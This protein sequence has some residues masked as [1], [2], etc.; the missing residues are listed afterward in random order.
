MTT[1]VR[2]FYTHTMKTAFFISLS[3]FGLLAIAGCG[4]SE[5]KF[6]KSLEEVLAIEKSRRG[7]IFA[8]DGAPGPYKEAGSAVGNVNT[9]GHI[10]AGEGIGRARISWPATEGYFYEGTAYLNAA[11]GAFI[12]VRKVPAP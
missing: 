8:Q 9:A 4:N 6:N 1:D 5:A 7:I 3:V 12:V 11:N 2:R 10:A